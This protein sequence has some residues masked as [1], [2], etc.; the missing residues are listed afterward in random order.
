MKTVLNPLDAQDFVVGCTLYGAGGGGQPEEG[1]AA[2]LEQVKAG[3]EVGWVDPRSLPGTMVT[4]CTFL[5]GST[6]PLTEAKRAE[7]KALGFVQWK[8][9]RNLPESVRQLEGFTGRR[10]DVLVPFELGGSN[11]P[12]PVAAAANLGILVVDGDYA[13][14]AVPEITQSTVGILNMPFL[15]AA[16]VDKW[17]N[18]AIITEA[19]SLAVA[20]RLGKYLSDAAYGSTGLTGF[21]M[22]LGDCRRALVEGS[23]SQALRA[24]RAMREAAAQGCYAWDALRPLGWRT[25]FQGT[26]TRKEWEDRDGYYWGTHTLESAG[27]VMEIIFKNE[28]HVSILNGE[29]FVTSPDVITCLSKSDGRPILNGDIAVGAELVVVAAPAPGLLRSEP[30]LRVLGPRY[31]GCDVCYR[32]LEDLVP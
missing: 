25:I 9:P 14:R 24:G 20:E 1:L 13:G 31:F 23:L 17:G 8:Y 26:V 4:A 22:P 6:A 11:T 19:T 10:I 21:L 15:P 7:M 18:R 27:E 28:N 2:L 3:R 12:A 16:S 5:M 29:P 32:P 30:A